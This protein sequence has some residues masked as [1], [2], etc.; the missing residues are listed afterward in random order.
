M[1]SFSIRRETN[2]FYDFSSGI[3]GN[4]FTFVKHY[5]KCSSKEAIDILSKYAGY[6]GV[7]T[8]PR[9]K[10]AATIICKRFKPQVFH[11]KTSSVSVYPENY[12]EKYEKRCDKLAVWELEGIS[13]ASLDKFQVYYD[14]FS[15][16]LVYPIRNIEGKIV[17]IGGRT[18]D[19]LWKE[20]KQRKY[21]YF[22]SWGT[23]DTIY[24]LVENMEHILKSRE[25]I[26][27][28][29]CKSV[30]LA[31]TWGIHNT[32]AILTS[33]LNPNQM[34]ILAQ[35]GCRV[36]FALDKDVRVRED[37]NISK[38]KQYVNVEYLWDREDLLDE[39]DAPVD[40]GLE[41]FKQLYE[42][43]LRYK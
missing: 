42:Q 43:R 39:K 38:L 29:G 10:L 5:N 1:P 26:L 19:P 27:F 4:V 18:L 22:H 7:T 25:V 24:G 15:D 12:M 36:V 6:D 32:G 30:L 20:K 21:T 9:K 16:R 40:K 34:K 31:D 41:V 23:M 37:H 8:A 2:S 35:L 14:S 33:H 13:R 17:N 28:E 3:G 11:K